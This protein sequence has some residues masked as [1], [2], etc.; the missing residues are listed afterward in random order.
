MTILARLFVL[1]LIAVLPAIAIQAYNEVNLRA[2]RS[3]EVHEQALRL[4]ESTAG[5][6]D[7]IVENGKGLL[8]AL[9]THAAVRGFDGDACSAYFAELKP[10]FPQFAV[11]GAADVDGHVFCSSRGVPTA[12]VLAGPYFK[13]ALTAGG[14]SI[15]ELVRGDLSQTNVLPLAM[16]FVD[17]DQQVAGIV[18]AALDVGWLAAAFQDK[19]F[20]G[21]ATLAITDRNATILARLPDNQ[22]YAG[23]SLGAYANLVYADRAGTADILGVDGVPRIVGYVPVG[24]APAEGI[25]IGVAL[26]K[27]DAFAAVD[28]ATR[29]GFALIGGGLTLA[30][31]AAWFGGR[32]FIS[33]PVARLAETASAWMRG[34][35]AARTRMK[36]GRS[37]LAR[38]GTAF[39]NIAQALQEHQR[40]VETLVATLEKRVEERTGALQAEIAQRE[41]A[42]AELLHAQK[43]EAVGQLTGGVAHD[44]NNLL[45]AIVGSL[46]LLDARIDPA[47]KRLTAM[48][49]R[50]AERG[51]KLT[52]QLLA[53]SRKQ[54]LAV[55]PTDINR[56][57]SGMSDIWRQ[58]LGGRI[59]LDISLAP[60]LWPALADEQQL[61]LCLLNLVINARD[62]M[63]DGGQLRVA[64]ANLR[65][66]EAKDDLPPGEYVHVSVEDS[67][68]GMDETVLRHVF[69]PFF[70]TKP[71]G[72]G[73]GL[74]LSMVYGTV[75]Q[76]GGSV[77]IVS[78]PGKGTRVSLRLPRAVEAVAKGRTPGERGGVAGQLTA[79]VL[80]VDDDPDVR[81]V[82]AAMLRELGHS[83]SEA[84]TGDDALDMI[85]RGAGLDCLITDYAMP[86]MSGEELRRRVE[87]LRPQ[88]PVILLTGYADVAAVATATNTRVIRKP[89]SSP[90]L[91]AAVEQAVC[92]ARADVIAMTSRPA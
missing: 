56:V 12:T 85:E 8:T 37:E 73:S 81:Q 26:T 86:R 25:Y 9:S 34:D 62:A 21:K 84:G 61:A 55:A 19:G 1:V 44:F 74:G 14:F 43:L 5:E 33:A 69:E 27:A 91:A 38:L 65:L 88:L 31:L 71:A 80:L 4:A 70:T 89:V 3:A 90:D 76:L 42:E 48:A 51:A 52:Q 41:R 47:Y 2:S 18:Y 36:A 13:R 67:G 58:T 46:D 63:P 7:R 20:E 53:F 23:S 68:L 15:G 29:F 72:Q 78:T 17:G 77:G 6:I 16:P 54:R 50:A 22:R 57:I 35:L 92:G 28:R 60:D 11:L 66:D 24:K 30:L 64:T 32:A 40:E 75:R 82:V 87:Q 39:D 59:G 10:N 83:V 79:R 45:M 49:R